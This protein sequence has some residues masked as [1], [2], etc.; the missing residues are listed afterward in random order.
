MNT[1]EKNTHEL[2]RPQY[3]ITNE[4]IEATVDAL[5]IK[6]DDSILSVCGSFDLPAALSEF[7][8]E[9]VFAFDKNLAQMGLLQNV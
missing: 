8:D 7:T 5:D 3:W 4:S 2:V 1:T 6:R 9:E